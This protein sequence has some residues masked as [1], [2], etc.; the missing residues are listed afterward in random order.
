MKFAI[1]G[2]IE[3]REL[4]DSRLSDRMITLMSSIQHF[5]VIIDQASVYCCI[6]LNILALIYAML[7]ENLQNAWTKQ[8]KELIWKC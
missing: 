5:I 4:Q 1:K 2:S 3:P 6:W 8:R 7:L